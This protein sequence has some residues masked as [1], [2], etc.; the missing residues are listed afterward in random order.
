MFNSRTLVNWLSPNRWY[1]GFRHGNVVFEVSFEKMSNVQ[2]YY[3]VE[4]RDYNAIAHHILLTDFEHS[5]LE[6]Y[7][8]TVDNGPWRYDTATKT[9]ALLG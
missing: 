6:R 2:N 9:N 3:W 8:P 1:D 7:D 4:T 5:E